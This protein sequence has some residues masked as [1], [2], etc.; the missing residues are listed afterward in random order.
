MNAGDYAAGSAS[1]VLAVLPW[2]PASGRIRRRLL[3]EWTGALG[4]LAQSVVG[5]AALVVI[6][7]LLGLAGWFSRWPLAGVSA[8][9]AAAAIWLCR[10]R[11]DGADVARDLPESRRARPAERT[12]L[13]L[14]AIAVLGV[15]TAI[16]GRA[17]HVVHTGPDD[18]DSLHYHLSE[19]ADLTLTHNLDHLHQTAASDESVY[20]PYDAELFDA[21]GMTGP[22][23]D[24]AT[25]GINLG[26]G[27]LALLACWVIGARWSVAPAATAAGAAVLALPLLAANS[28]GPGLNDIPSAGFLLAAIALLVHAG[29]PRG[30]R[31]QRAWL[32]EIGAVG[33]ALGLAAGSKLSLLAPVVLLAL[34]AIALARRDWWRVLAVLVPTA[35]LTGGLWYLRDWVLVGTP[36][37]GLNLVVAGHG[38][39]EIPNPEV[40]P[41]D[42]TVAH[43][44]GNWSVIHH[45]FT[46][47]LH[48]VWTQVWPLV[49]LLILAGLLLPIVVDRQ[50]VRRMLGIVVLLAVG[51][52]LITPTTALGQP[53]APVLF[54]ANTRYAVPQMILSMVLLATIEPLRRWR[55]LVTLG[56]TA[57]TIGML[58]ATRTGIFIDR[59]AGLAAALVA[60]GAVGWIFAAR[61]RGGPVIGA[62][63]GVAVLLAAIGVG[64]A[65][66]RHYV[67]ERYAAVTSSPTSTDPQQEL[68]SLGR[69]VT[70]TRIGIVGHA[71]QYPFY[72]PDLTNHVGYVGVT[73]PDGSYG[74]PSSCPAWRAALAGQRDRY[75][76][77]EPLDAEHT[78]QITRWT[79]AIPGARQIFHNPAG[80][81]FQL[82][83]HIPLTGCR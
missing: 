76:V 9:A 19:A 49:G 15:T 28:S 39:H 57:V 21:I 16:L 33:L 22:H 59:S 71:L 54:A 78:P 64:A 58:A 23:P 68:F 6:C 18:L 69:K 72:G 32:V 34:G 70:D 29:L 52:Y 30:G 80:T 61:L 46:P 53:G 5:I 50:P 47:G 82:P 1:L 4:A 67:K 38:L 26:F 3:P 44:L 75:L 77:I 12:A 2:I 66:Q 40:A 51:A 55:T 14:A 20:Y 73:A 8:G 45:W 74:A 31:P 7:Q 17:A 37:P 65:I 13:L 41:Y 25:L 56:F 10:P 42:F 83:R 79:A 24:L 36:L 60:L 81:V 62:V 48:A 63:A 43:Y 35:L 11:S 27:W